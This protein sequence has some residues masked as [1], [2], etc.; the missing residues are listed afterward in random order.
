MSVITQNID[1][2]PYT[3]TRKVI[4]KV[5]V[6]TSEEASWLNGFFDGSP[7]YSQVTGLTRGKVYDVVKVEGFGDCE[8]ITIVDDFGKERSFGDFFFTEVKENPKEEIKT[9]EENPYFEEIKNTVE[10]YKNKVNLKL[11]SSDY[12]KGFCYGLLSYAHSWKEINDDE[13][14][15][16]AVVVD[17]AFDI[18]EKDDL[19]EKDL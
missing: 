3:G 4:G 16:L 1:S 18:P 15:E 14:D 19:E 2:H 11:C 10:Q 6:K 12:A 5:R 9:T 8:D 17:D 13:Y 7:D